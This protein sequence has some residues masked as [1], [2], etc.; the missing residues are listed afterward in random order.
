MEDDADLTGG[1]LLPGLNDLE[2]YHHTTK[3]DVTKLFRALARGSRLER[4][5]IDSH[6]GDR[7]AMRDYLSGANAIGLRSLTIR[8]TT[9]RRDAESLCAAG[10]LPDLAALTLGHVAPDAEALLIDRF[11]PRYNGFWTG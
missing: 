4:L 6:P 10:A 3:D 8:G 7:K 1:D 11:G 2:V 5:A 9:T